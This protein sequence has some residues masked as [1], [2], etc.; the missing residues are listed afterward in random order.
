MA[1]SVDHP[2]RVDGDT[3]FRALRGEILAGVHPPGTALREVVISER[4]GVSRT[5]VREALSRLQ[6][7]RLLERAARGL[8]VPQIDPQQVIQIYDLRV[9]L[10]EEAAGQAALNRG[11]ADLMR[12]EALLERDRAVVDPEDT[13]RVT[14]NLEFHTSLWAAARNPILMDLLQRLSTHLIH[15]PRSTLSVGNRWQEVLGEHEA[16]ISAIAER[17]SDDARAL[18]RTHMETARTLRLQ[19]LRTSAAG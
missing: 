8:Q 13:V 17:R 16:L 9:M 18:A 19:L 3:I 10:E 5:P 11:D 12:L 15:T 7:E 4:F 6:H 1:E 14:N 2:T